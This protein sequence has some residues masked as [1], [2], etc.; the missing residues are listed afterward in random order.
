M[1]RGISTSNTS[2]GGFTID[3]QRRSQ[4]HTNSIAFATEDRRSSSR[5]VWYIATN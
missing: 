4:V 5:N 1:K 2:A 3:Q